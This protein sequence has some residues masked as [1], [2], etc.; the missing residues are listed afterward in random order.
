MNRKT[1]RAYLRSY[2][3]NVRKIRF[4]QQPVKLGKASVSPLVCAVT[5]RVPREE[6]EVSS[7]RGPQVN[8]QITE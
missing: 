4:M 6:P 2:L 8:F 1:K 3:K 5:V 7:S